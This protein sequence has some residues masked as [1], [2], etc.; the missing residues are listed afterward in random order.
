MRDLSGVFRSS[1][2]EAMARQSNDEEG[3]R[4][5]FR[6]SKRWSQLSRISGEA[7]VRYCTTCRS[8]VHR[9]LTECEFEKEAAAGNCVALDLGGG[10]YMI[11]DPLPLDHQGKRT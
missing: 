5:S 10:Q 8:A 4:L 3:L 7:G 9:V 1:E 6:C 11:G 2:D